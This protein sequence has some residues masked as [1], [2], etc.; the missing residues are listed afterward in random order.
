MPFNVSKDLSEAVKADALVIPCY[1]SDTPLKG[2]KYA[3]G[4]EKLFRGKAEKAEKG[5]WKITY[6]FEDPKQLEDFREVTEIGRRTPVKAHRLG[7]G[8]VDGAMRALRALHGR[9]ASRTRIGEFLADPSR[10][11][12]VAT[13][14]RT[15]VEV[16]VEDQSVRCSAS[17]SHLA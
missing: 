10:H 16:W 7:P 11:M 13:A 15:P 6:D 12:Y 3:A 5:R 9:C 4:V 1:E 2:Y 14:A 8:D 17:L